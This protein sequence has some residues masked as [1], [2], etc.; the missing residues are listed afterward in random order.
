[1]TTTTP[2]PFNRLLL[3]G[4]AGGLGPTA[5]HAG[6]PPASAPRIRCEITAHFV[7]V[8]HPAGPRDR[9]CRRDRRAA[10]KERLEAPKQ[11]SPQQNMRICPPGQIVPCWDKMEPSTQPGQPHDDHTMCLLSMLYGKTKHRHGTCWPCEGPPDQRSGRRQ[12]IGDV[13]TLSRLTSKNC[14]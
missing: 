12:A 9:A 13:T 11:P 10:R 14:E 8:P 6:T 4:A 7:P 5:T 1:M 2:A 3:T